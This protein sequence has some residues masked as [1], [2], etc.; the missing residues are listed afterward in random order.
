MSEPEQAY[1]LPLADWAALFRPGIEEFAASSF[2]FTRES[3]HLVRIA[4]G[5][6]GPYIDSAGNRQPVYTHAVTLPPEL[7]LQL[8][9][10]LMKHYAAPEVTKGST[11]SD[12]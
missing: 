6:G 8:A 1:G 9:D 5:N 7:A 3:T 10:Q 2:R 12:V 4:F 11:G